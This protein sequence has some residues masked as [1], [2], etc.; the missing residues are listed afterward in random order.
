LETL[1]VPTTHPLWAVNLATDFGDP[2]TIIDAAV[3]TATARA[4]V[5][6]ALKERGRSLS[7]VAR[8][9]VTHPHPRHLGL[10]GWIQTRSGA[11][12][13]LLERDWRWPWEES[14]RTEQQAT[15]LREHG[16]PERWIAAISGEQE[17]IRGQ[18]A[19]L[20]QVS[21]LRPGQTLAL[22]GSTY[23]VLALPGHEDGHLGL[24]CPERRFAVLGDVLGPG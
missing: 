8:V 9:I 4:L 11:A 22:G 13:F 12:V 20:G 23:L 7:E 3:N 6:R 19:P 5:E 18:V 15:Y 14:E 24:W 2:L 21:W 16:L 10:A 17:E 1:A